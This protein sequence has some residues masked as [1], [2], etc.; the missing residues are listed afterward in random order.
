MQHADARKAAV[1]VV[2][3]IAAVLLALATVM[4][5]E[6]GTAAQRTWEATAR[7][8]LEES[9]AER[10]PVVPASSFGDPYYDWARFTAAAERAA[11]AAP[12]SRRVAADPDTTLRLPTQAVPGK[13]R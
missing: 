8:A 5:P 9:L 10:S 1:A 4:V 6:V 2:A 7:P 12:A 11:E 13:S 3:L